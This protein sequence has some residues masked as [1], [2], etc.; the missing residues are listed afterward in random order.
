MGYHAVTNRRWEV[1]MAKDHGSSVKND[2][3]YEGLRKKGMSKSRAAAISVARW[4]EQRQ[5]P[6]REEQRLGQRL[7]HGLL[8]RRRG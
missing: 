2:K 4:E 5:Q 7:S 8:R 3:Q 1:V 6:E